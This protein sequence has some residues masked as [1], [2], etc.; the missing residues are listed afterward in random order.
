MI[1]HET[2]TLRVPGATIHYERWGAGPL[3][4]IIPGGPQ[5]AGVFADLAAHLGD[6]YT[7]LSF[8]PRGNSRT[9]T[10]VG[11]GDLD[12]DL[13]ADDVAALIAAGGGRPAFVF[14]TSGGAQIGLSLAARH[15]A[16]VSV[17]IA[18]EPPSTM[19]LADP[20]PALAGDRELQDI[21]RRE[22][23]EAAMG[24]FF[25]QNGLDGPPDDDLPPEAAETF[26]RV[27]G[28]FEYWLAHGMLP[29][30]TYRPD[31]EILRDG[32]AHVVVAI[33]RGSA[34]QPIEAMGMALA[35]HLDIDPTPFPGD[36]MGYLG[37]ASEFADAID[38]AFREGRHG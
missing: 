9:L 27:A 2:G 15:P 1:D 7:V 11:A 22:G 20:E 31:V 26:A 13:L 17:L 18:H 34:G 12:V 36:H 10:D 8:D 14:G 19:L 5:D 37:D 35:R 16:S 28:N 3:L 6:R 38:R 24:A 30:A 21:Y 32:P 4:V 33:G 25:A 29:L 23:I